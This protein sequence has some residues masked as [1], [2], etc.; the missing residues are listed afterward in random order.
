MEACVLIKGTG[1]KGEW[2]QLLSLVALV[3]FCY[4]YIPAELSVFPLLLAGHEL[5][6]VYLLR[7]V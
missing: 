7:C 6:I 1:L 5:I 3:S 2:R 4:L